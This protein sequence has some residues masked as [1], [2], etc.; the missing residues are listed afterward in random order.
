MLFF[1][2]PGPPGIFF[3]G[4]VSLLDD[5]GLMDTLLFR[6]QPFIMGVISICE[7]QED[8]NFTSSSMFRSSTMT[9]MSCII[10]TGSRLDVTTAEVELTGVLPDEVKVDSIFLT[11]GS[12]DNIDGSTLT[13]EIINVTSK[14]ASVN[15]FALFSAIFLWYS[16]FFSYCILPSLSLYS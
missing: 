12:C 7:K 11:L 4:N 15:T 5:F 2:P 1:P 3:E 6:L 14:Y 10:P 16:L 13:S 8:G 9:D